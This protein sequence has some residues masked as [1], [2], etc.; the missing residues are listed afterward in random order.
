M[1][2][3][4][5]YKNLFS[6][7]NLMINYAISVLYSSIN[8]DSCGNTFFPAV[9]STFDYVAQD[10]Y[11]RNGTPT[12]FASGFVVNGEEANP[13]SFPWQVL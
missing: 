2:G 11:V 6:H 8:E 1:M 4:V 5:L 12:D 9:F 13:Y 3:L 7:Y 10:R